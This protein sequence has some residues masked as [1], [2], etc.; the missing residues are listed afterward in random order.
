MIEFSKK[1]VFVGYGAV[2][3][4]TLPILFKHIKVAPK[5]VTVIDFEAKEEKL[6]QWTK[7]GVNYFRE[8]VTE[9]NMHSLLGKHLSEG[10]IL[11]DLAWNIDACEILQWCHDKG[12]RYINTSVEVWDPYAG[13]KKH[14]TERT[15]YWRH[16]NL[17]RMTAKWKEKGP[18][19]VIEHGANP[20][21]ISHF[22]K[23]GLIDIAKAAVSEKKLKGKKAELVTGLAS[24]G[25]F[26]HLA[27]ALGVKVI[28]CSERDTQITDVPKQIDEF[29]NTW[30]IEG[31]REE[32]TTTAELGWGT[33]EKELP[34]YAFQHKEGPKNQICIA[35][36]GMNTWVRS[37]VPNYT[38]NGMVVRHGE[39]FTISDKLTV[40][41]G[42]KAVYRPT[43]HYAYCPC[44]EAIV[45]LNELRGYNYKLQPKLRIMNDEITK[46]ADILGALI[47]GHPFNSWWCGSDLTIEES[48]RLVP[49]QNATTMQVAIS[50][51]AATM[52]MIENPQEGVKV[53]DELPHT[54]VLGV[55]KPYLGKFIST[56]SDWTPMKDYE[57]AFSGFNKPDFD[58][59]DPWQFKNFL[60]KDGD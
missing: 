49:H 54:Y 3:E 60:I 47:M 51:V 16:M 4:C 1:I 38:I 17:R 55:S 22:V 46:G 32:G 37:W 8:R 20:G 53:P 19:A 2:A 45:S 5:N 50:V 30:S 44:D 14:P 27:R 9:E 34:K 56:R 24:E 25:K 43:M 21:L 57:N 39:A 35:R 58:K 31:F 28:H 40:W 52:W 15:L 26:N 48:R 33:H 42:K 7:K 13:G 59:K 12:I 10:D 6:A 29:V 18:T 41:E 36:M 23:Q 11:I